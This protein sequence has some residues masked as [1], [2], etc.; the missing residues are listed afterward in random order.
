MLINVKDKS[1]QRQLDGHPTKNIS[2][3]LKT[4]FRKILPV[5]GV[6]TDPD[7]AKTSLAVTTQL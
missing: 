3:F 1:Y 7:D 2:K 5:F 6:Q 4:F